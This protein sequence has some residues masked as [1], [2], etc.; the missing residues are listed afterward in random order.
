MGVES[1]Q[2]DR[3]LARLVADYAGR[4][5][6]AV[7]DQHHDDWVFSPLGA[8]MLLAAGPLGRTG[9]HTSV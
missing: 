9:D 1:E 3:R 6:G 7:A 8:W 5:R 4:V 2:I